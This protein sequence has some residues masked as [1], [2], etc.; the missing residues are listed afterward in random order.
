MLKIHVDSHN[1]R[2]FLESEIARTLGAELKTAWEM[3]VMQLE[4][5]LR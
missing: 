5:K 4:G 1:Q 3:A 2:L